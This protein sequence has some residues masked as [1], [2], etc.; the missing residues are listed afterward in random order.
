MGEQCIYEIY[1]KTDWR[2]YFS[3]CWQKCWRCNT[4]AMLQTQRTVQVKRM[5]MAD[6]P[7]WC[8]RIIEGWEGIILAN[9]NLGRGFRPLIRNLV[10]TQPS[11]V[12][13]VKATFSLL[14]GG[15]RLAHERAELLSSNPVSVCFVKATACKGQM[16]LATC[17]PNWCNLSLWKARRMT[18][19][20]SR[21]ES[22]EA[23]I[24]V[25]CH[26]AA[27]L[28]NVCRVWPADN[29]NRN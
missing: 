12:F 21:R 29:R 27:Q 2:I 28:S 11:L 25:F 24:I 10:Q 3:T 18:P 26:C 22:G 5:N 8:W 14:R 23:A 9:R 6:W 7:A 15:E 1:L 17:F 4:S 19:I 16:F 13:V 20:G